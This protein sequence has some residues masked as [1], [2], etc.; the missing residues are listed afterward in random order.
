MFDQ[1]D[2]WATALVIF[3]SLI[4]VKLGIQNL[5]GGLKTAGNIITNIQ[6]GINRY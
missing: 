6:L 3:V 4:A 2:L 5:E 1:R